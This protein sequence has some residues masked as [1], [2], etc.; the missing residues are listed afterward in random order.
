MIEG[1]Y[2]IQINGFA[3]LQPFAQY[4][5]QPNGTGAVQNSAVLG[6]YTGVDF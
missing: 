6:F 2:R 3:F 4:I 5:F 1:G